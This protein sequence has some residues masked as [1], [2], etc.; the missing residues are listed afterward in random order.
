MPGN[1]NIL[2]ISMSSCTIIDGKLW[3]GYTFSYMKY[4]N[5]IDLFIPE[6]RLLG[7]FLKAAEGN[8]IMDL[9]GTRSRASRYMRKTHRGE[10][11]TGGNA[12]AV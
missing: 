10:A 3:I 12:C 7:Q 8:K 4:A 5:K 9:G 11:T 1:A 6:I 2:G